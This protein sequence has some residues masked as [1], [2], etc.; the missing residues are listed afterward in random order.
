MKRTK[1]LVSIS[2][3][4]DSTFCL[5]WAK[6]KFK[7]VEAVIFEYG[8]RHEIEMEA[9]SRVCSEAGVFL[10]RFCVP[11]LKQIAGGALTSSDKTKRTQHAQFPTLP[12]TFIP[13]RNLVLFSTAA[14]WAVKR[15][16]PNLIVGICQTDY[17]G[18]PDCRKQ[19]ITALGVA[20]DL[21]LDEH[22]IEIWTPLMYLT[23]AEMI[24]H[25]QK[26]PGLMEAWAYT[27][28]CYNNVFP[29]CGEC[30]ACKL[31]AKGFAEA[32][33]EDPLILRAKGLK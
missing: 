5:Y 4:Q 23:K 9:A 15:E 29:P 22:R 21:A 3:G 12:S 27:H 30:D 6:M 20:I 11:A 13:L 25:A 17:S 7:E 24:R 2:G 1:A 16:I 31:R 14:A 26:V 8:Q 32:G 28:T 18:Y 33:V 19:F 10:F